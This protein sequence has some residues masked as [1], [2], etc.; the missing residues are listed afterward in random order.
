MDEEKIELKEDEV[1]V[2]PVNKKVSKINFIIIAVI[3]IGLTAYMIIVDGIDNI[4]NIL[5]QV[6]YRWVFAGL[7]CLLIHWFCESINLHIPIKKMYKNQKFTNSIKVTMIGLLF[8]NITP[9]ATGG[10]PMQAYEL[11]KTGKR[12]SDSASA[13]A[14]KFAI[15]QSALVITTLIVAIFQLDFF[16]TMMKQYLWITIL[17]FSINIIAIVG[18]ILL[19]INP[20]IIKS[21][22][23][24]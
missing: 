16:I 1:D 23:K 19:G 18:V 21:I 4:I 14:M 11:T 24:F 2:K 5:T 9:F 7:I 6:D 15:T 13:L 17:G 20:K 10:Q 3:F 22:S 8:N 12:I